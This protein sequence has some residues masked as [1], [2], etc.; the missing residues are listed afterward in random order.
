MTK[1]LL[2]TALA[3]VALLAGG[4]CAVRETPRRGF[5]D[6]FAT[7]DGNLRRV[8]LEPLPARDLGRYRAVFVEPVQVRAAD[9]TPDE[10]ATL[11]AV[12]RE[13]LRQR[14]GATRRLAA[15]ARPDA[16]R[17]RAAVTAVVRSDAPLNPL[18]DGAFSLTFLNGGAAAEAE[19]LDPRTGER[20]A[21]LVLAD[22]RRLA[23]PFG[24]YAR[25]GHARA[26]LEDLAADFALLIAPPATEVARR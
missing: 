1:A 23:R 12:F 9:L 8:V 10:A 15:S 18:T 2:A 7:P 21:A 22:E 26:V 17:V 6:G 20:V 25:A 13:A 3:A 14:L 11:Q 4:G 16:L 24:D 5:V 19:A